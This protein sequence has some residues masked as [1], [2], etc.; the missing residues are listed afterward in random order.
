M[1]VMKESISHMLVIYYFAYNLY[2]D[3]KLIFK[4]HCFTFKKVFNKFLRE[5]RYVKIIIHITCLLNQFY[6]CIV[7]CRTEH[8]ITVLLWLINLKY[9]LTYIENEYNTHRWIISRKVLINIRLN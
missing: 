3:D 6:C 2:V 7:A 9:C 4:M 1:N 5:S 8:Y